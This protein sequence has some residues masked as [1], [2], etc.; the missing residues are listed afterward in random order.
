MDRKKVMYLYLYFDL[1]NRGYF[2]TFDLVSQLLS[3]KK[4]KVVKK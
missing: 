3:V 2:K 1:A 4:I